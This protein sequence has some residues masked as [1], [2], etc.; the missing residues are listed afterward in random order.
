MPSLFSNILFLLELDDCFLKILY[1][2][3]IDIVLKAKINITIFRVISL[4]IYKFL[5]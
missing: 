5:I 4:K 3:N 1:L 2:I